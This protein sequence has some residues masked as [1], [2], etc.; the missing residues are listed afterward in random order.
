MFKEF[1]PD[2]II[3]REGEPANRFYLIRHGKIALESRGDGESAP[4]VQFVGEGEALGWSWLFA[5]YYWHFSARAVEPTGVIF[6]YG[7]RL[8]AQ[9]DEDPAFGYE[10]MKRMAAIVIK[11][12]QIARVQLIQLQQDASARASSPVQTNSPGT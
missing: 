12:L 3:F 2:E 7:T 1:E 6:F 11:R 8:R 9:C 4:L 10:L 5:P